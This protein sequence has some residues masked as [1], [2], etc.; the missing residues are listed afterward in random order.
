VSEIELRWF[1]D[2][3]VR[4]PAG[5]AGDV[6][7]QHRSRE[8]RH[9]AIRLVEF[10]P[11]GSMHLMRDP[12]DQYERV[13]RISQSRLEFLMGVTEFYRP[14]TDTTMTIAAE[15]LAVIAAVTR[16]ATLAVIVPRLSVVGPMIT[17]VCSSIAIPAGVAP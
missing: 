9:R 8:I 13:A 3:G 15:R 14:R 2:D 17:T 6:G 5:A 16:V 4:R 12:L 11:P 1:D 7:C 10:P